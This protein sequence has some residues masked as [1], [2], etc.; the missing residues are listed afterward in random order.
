MGTILWGPTDVKNREYYKIAIIPPAIPLSNHLCSLS[1]W[2]V[3]FVICYYLVTLTLF[4]WHYSGE[5]FISIYIFGNCH[6]ILLSLLYANPYHYIL[7]FQ[8]HPHPDFRVGG[9]WSGEWHKKVSP[10]VWFN[11]VCFLILFVYT[12]NVMRTKAI[13]NNSSEQVLV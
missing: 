10:K 1:V 6:M 3:A 9:F 13:L 2:P 7:H 4:L 8:S 11:R 12:W 5:R